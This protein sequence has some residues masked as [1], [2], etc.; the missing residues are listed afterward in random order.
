MKI[1]PDN[2]VGGGD[3]PDWWRDKA[4][5]V[6]VDRTRVNGHVGKAE[7]SVF[8]RYFS[9]RRS[10]SGTA[11]RDACTFASERVS[12]GGRQ[13]HSADNRGAR[14]DTSN[15]GRR[16]EGGEYRGDQDIALWPHVTP[17]LHGAAIDSDGNPAGAPSRTSCET[18]IPW[19]A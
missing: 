11:E 7:R 4:L 16:N 3:H 8:I 13:R 12:I 15:G 9:P 19:S 14:T 6:R 2:L 1:A 5:H 17:L 18:A 10:V